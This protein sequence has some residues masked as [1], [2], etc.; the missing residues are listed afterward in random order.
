MKG[1]DVTFLFLEVVKFHKN[2]MEGPRYSVVEYLLSMHET[3]GLVLEYCQTKLK[4]NSRY[5]PDILMKNDNKILKQ[6]NLFAKA[7]NLE[8]F[9]ST[10]VH[11]EKNIMHIA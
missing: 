5:Y 1:L 7:G 3:L 10:I 8:S 4:S 2:T 11:I 9:Y 6:Q